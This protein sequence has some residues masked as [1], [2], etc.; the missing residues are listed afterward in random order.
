MKNIKYVLLS[1]AF[2]MSTNTLSTELSHY[3]TST[4]I[5]R[6]PS[7]VVKGMETYNGMDKKYKNTTLLLNPDGTWKVIDLEATPSFYPKIEKLTGHWVGQSA[8]FPGWE[9]VGLCLS[10]SGDVGVGWQRIGGYEISLMQHEDKLTGV[11]IGSVSCRLPAIGKL[12]GRLTN[13][14]LSFT[15]EFNGQEYIK[16]EGKVSGDFS[17]IDGTVKYIETGTRYYGDEEGLSLSLN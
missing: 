10:V 13:K 12:T 14:A 7:L 11:V 15:I 4:Q 17:R 2:L 8:S 1:G 16:F 9:S 6:I 3:D 5:L